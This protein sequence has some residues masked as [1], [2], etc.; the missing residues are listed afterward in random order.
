MAQGLMT[1]QDDTEATPG[2]EEAKLDSLPLQIYCVQNWEVYVWGVGRQGV[3][4]L[5]VVMGRSL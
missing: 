2:R 5:A 4:S 1:G 3:G